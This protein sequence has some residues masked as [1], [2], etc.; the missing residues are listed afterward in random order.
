MSGVPVFHLGFAAHQR[1]VANGVEV[2]SFHPGPQHRIGL[3]GDLLD[4]YLSCFPH[5][6]DLA[7]FGPPCLPRL[8][9]PDLDLFAVA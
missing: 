1:L 9:L 6:S 5:Q 8:R 2:E 3:R 4:I 7:A